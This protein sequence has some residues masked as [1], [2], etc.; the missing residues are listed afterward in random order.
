MLSQFL[1]GMPPAIFLFLTGI[2]LAFLMHSFERRGLSPWRRITGTLGRARY[3]LIVAILF[4]LQLWVFSWPSPAINLLKV[5]IL[6]C[7][8]VAIALASVLAIF[9]TAQRVRFGAALG[10]FIAAFSPLVSQMNW[11]GVPWIVKAYLVPDYNYFSLFPW[12]A[13]L[14]FGMSAGSLLRLVKGEH[15]D[16]V[17]QW[18]ALLGIAL[19]LVARYFANLPFSIYPKSEFW[20]DSPAQILIKLGVTLVILAVA[21][22]WTQ[23]GAAPGWSWVCQFGTTSLLVYWVH[24]ELVYGRWLPWCKNNLDVW[25]TSV[26]A[27]VMIALMLLLAVTKTYHN[28][29]AAYLVPGRLTPVPKSDRVAAD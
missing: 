7:M 5:D 2:T 13:Y 24:I 17:M 14:L 12:A 11:T 23:Y 4:R 3:L 20:L 25:Q 27:V 1:G 9:T 6:N 28:T 18:S 21:F 10:L 15:L 29:I 22:V 26:A 8:G 19:V 16:R